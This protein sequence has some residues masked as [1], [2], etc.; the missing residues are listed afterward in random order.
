VLMPLEGAPSSGI[1]TILIIVM[2][3]S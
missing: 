1:N 3:V 2:V